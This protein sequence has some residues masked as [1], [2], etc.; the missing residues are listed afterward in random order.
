MSHDH[1]LPE[2]ESRG[3]GRRSIQK[4]AGAHDE[5]L[6]KILQHSSKSKDICEAP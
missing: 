3:Q 4:L 6:K 1:G 2:I 5:F